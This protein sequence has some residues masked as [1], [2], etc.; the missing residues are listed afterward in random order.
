MQDTH[1]FYGA[2]IPGENGLYNLTLDTT[3][4]NSTERE[5]IANYILTLTV[6]VDGYQAESIIIEC[7]INGIVTQTNLL[8]NISDSYEGVSFE[9]YPDFSNII[10]PSNPLPLRVKVYCLTAWRYPNMG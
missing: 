10:N 1:I 3:G 7:P 4:L 9:K 8:S 2:K 6:S 5:N